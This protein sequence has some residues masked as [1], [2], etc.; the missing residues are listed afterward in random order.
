M[1][2]VILAMTLVFVLMFI[3]EVISHKL[4]L[5]ISIQGGLHTTVVVMFIIWSIF[6]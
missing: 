4:N 1:I 6:R 2:H 5:S 3:I